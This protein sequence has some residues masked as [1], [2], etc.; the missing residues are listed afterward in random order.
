MTSRRLAL[1]LLVALGLMSS[2][3]ALPSPSACNDRIP[4]P[5][6]APRFLGQNQGCAC[7]ECN[8]DTPKAQTI[9]TSDA[10]KKRTLFAKAKE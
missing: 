5:C 2:S 7:F 6:N 1:L 9:C 4:D 10:E 8:P 3:S